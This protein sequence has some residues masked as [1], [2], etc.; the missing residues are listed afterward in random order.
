ST[1]IIAAA[2]ATGDTVSY[3]ITNDSYDKLGRVDELLQVQ[4]NKESADLTAEQVAPSGLIPNQI[5][6]LVLAGTNGADAVD[7]VLPMLRLP[8]PA[9]NERTK[10]NSPQVVA[11]G[12]DERFMAG[13]EDDLVAANGTGRVNLAILGKNDVFI[14]E[15]AARTLHVVSGDR[16]DLWVNRQPRTFFVRGIVK[17]HLI[18]G[19]TQGEPNGVVMKLSAAQDL[20][21][22]RGVGLLGISNKGGVRDSVGGTEA[23]GRLINEAIG[24]SR[25]QLN[26]NKRNRIERARELGSNLTA[27]FVV[28]GLFSI[29]AGLL[30]VFLILV[31]L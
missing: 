24:D 7:G 31:M 21:K 4:E 2:L 16:V 6:Q 14:N 15:S 22:L 29:A 1:V 11:I 9:T 28:L 19:W 27:L 18:T 3:S 10:E 5:T 12:I 17:D 23:T 8:V 25:F 20:F 26:P 13:F 30:M